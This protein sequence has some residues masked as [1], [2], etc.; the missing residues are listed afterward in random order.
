M[1]GHA[2]RGPEPGRRQGARHGP[3]QVLTAEAPWGCGG[4]DR[5]GGVTRRRCARPLRAPRLAGVHRP[6]SGSSCSQARVWR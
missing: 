4:P 2:I 6:S 3:E 1:A 5:A